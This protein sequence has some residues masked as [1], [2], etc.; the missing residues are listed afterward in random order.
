M[1]DGEGLNPVSVNGSDFKLERRM[2]NDTKRLVGV[3]HFCA[4]CP[5]RIFSL[6]RSGGVS[7]P[8]NPGCHWMGAGWER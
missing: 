2:R 3:F 6:S 4:F 7:G 5:I 1:M 8:A